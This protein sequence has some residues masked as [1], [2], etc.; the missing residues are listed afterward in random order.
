MTTPKAE[1]TTA[2]VLAGLRHDDSS[3]RL[4]AALAAGADPTR[5]SWSRWWSGA[6][7]N[8]CSMCGTC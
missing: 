7:W 8:P 6:G 3:V 1:T 4:R 5:S 2:R